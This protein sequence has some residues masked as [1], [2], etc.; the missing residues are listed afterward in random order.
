VKLRWQFPGEK[1]VEKEIM[2]EKAAQFMVI[3]GQ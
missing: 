1:P 3:K 2:I